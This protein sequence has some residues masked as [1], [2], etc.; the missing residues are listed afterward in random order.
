MTI[1]NPILTMRDWLTDQV[2][3]APAYMVV[4]FAV[5]AVAYVVLAVHFIMHMRGLNVSFA[6]KKKKTA[7]L[8]GP[9]HAGKTSFLHFVRDGKHVETVSS[10][11][12]KTYNFSVHPK[13]NPDKFDAELTVIDYPGH[14]RLRSRVTEFYPI[15]SCIAFFVDASDVPSF[16][17]AAEFLYDVFANKKINDQ[18][19]PIMIVCNK[20][21]ITT[22]ASPQ[23]VRDAL[24]KELTQL[25]TT[26]SSL[27]IEGDEDE[28]DRLQVPV[29]RDAVPFQF[30][31][32]APC[33]ISFI[34]CSVKDADI[35]EVVRF[36]QQY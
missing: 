22:A 23:A 3:G 25:K 35:E 34:K 11:K 31:V 8:L 5:I 24:E 12:E 10:M 9:R 30:D 28:Q 29:G 32:D 1:P 26:R 21:E 2:Y 16:R 14:E 17:K 27:E 4:P 18:A 33:D 6:G 19:P 36:I 20:S 15:T 7:L 13:Y